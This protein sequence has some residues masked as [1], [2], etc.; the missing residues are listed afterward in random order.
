[1]T[2]IRH[3]IDQ[4][5]VFEIAEQ[6]AFRAERARHD[7]ERRR[8]AEDRRSEPRGGRRA[9]DVNVFNWLTRT[10]AELD[11]ALAQEWESLDSGAEEEDRSGRPEAPRGDPW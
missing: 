8:A 4:L 2:R 3:R 11:G 5:L 9:D 7:E 6:L 1:M 10:E